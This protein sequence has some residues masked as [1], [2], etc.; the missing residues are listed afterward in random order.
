MEVEFCS[1]KNRK[2]DKKDSKRYDATLIEKG[3]YIIP[4]EGRLLLDTIIAK[5]KVSAVQ[6][7]TMG[8]EELMQLGIGDR[9]ESGSMII[10]HEDSLLQVEN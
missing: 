9:I 7:T 4:S 1:I 3:D 6:G 8:S 10:S 2:L 5:G